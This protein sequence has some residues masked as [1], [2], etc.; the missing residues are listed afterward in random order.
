MAITITRRKTLE[1]V[2]LWPAKTKIFGQ[3]VRVRV[4]YDRSPGVKKAW[5]VGDV[6]MVL[7]RFPAHGMWDKQPDDDLYEV[8]MPS[9]RVFLSYKEVECVG[10]E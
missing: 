7:Q 4:K 10:P 6:G 2:G 9:E 1:D 3:G 5:K 8:Q